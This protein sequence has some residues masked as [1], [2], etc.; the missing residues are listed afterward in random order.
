METGNATGTWPQTYETALRRYIGAGSSASLQPANR[1]GRQAAALGIQTLYVVTIHK[2]AMEDLVSLGSTAPIRQAI[3]RRANGFFGE[4]IIPI[5][6][7]HH[8]A[9]LK[10]ATRVDDQPRALQTH[11]RNQMR[12]ILA[13]QEDERQHH[14]RYLYDEIARSVLAIHLQL[15]KWRTATRLNSKA[16]DK[17]VAETQCLLKQC[18]E[19]V[20]WLTQAFDTWQNE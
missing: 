9:V 18:G 10:I 11:L 1:L 17:E 19:K 6:K 15:A 4:T 12:T 8:H 14:N 5:E 2:Q 20:A 13:L 16:L 7:A 3:I